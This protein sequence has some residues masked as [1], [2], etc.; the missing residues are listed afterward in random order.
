[1][2][3]QTFILRCQNLF[4]HMPRTSFPLLNVQPTLLERGVVQLSPCHP[5][6]NLSLFTKLVVLSF[7]GTV[8]CM[9][10]AFFFF[11]CMHGANIF[12]C[13]R[14][15]FTYQKK[16]DFLCLECAKKISPS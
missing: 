13:F 7:D 10:L 16:T 4:Y 3:W 15:L 11:D 2:D 12:Y 5:S 6:F 8:V 14:L 9:W 1:M